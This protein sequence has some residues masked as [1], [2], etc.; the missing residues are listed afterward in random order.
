MYF[1]ADWA[2]KIAEEEAPSGS[3]RYV[4][5]PAF[6]P[7]QELSETGQPKYHRFSCAGY[8]A[9]ALKRGGVELCDCS[10]LPLA[11]ATFLAPAYPILP[12]I[13]KYPKK[14]SQFGV[15]ADPPW[16]ILLP[17]YLFHGADAFIKGE[18]P[19][20]PALSMACYT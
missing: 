15:D 14:R 11:D 9:E 19:I 5:L 17:G 13:M 4:I 7:S 18:G 3:D 12:A 6:E 8:V 16:P 1:I 20:A 2:A 10:N